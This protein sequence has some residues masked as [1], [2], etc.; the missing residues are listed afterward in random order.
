LIN[1]ISRV[2]GHE[3]P[4]NWARIVVLV[5]VALPVLGFLLERRSRASRRIRLA[6]GERV[7]LN[8]GGPIGLVVETGELVTI[9]WPAGEA[10][11]PLECLHRVSQTESCILELGSRYPAG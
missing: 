7:R 8:R 11:F 9:A 3:Q 4:I 1:P 6:I 2:N 10:T 5:A